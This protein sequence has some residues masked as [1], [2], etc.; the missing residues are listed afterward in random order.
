MKSARWNYVPREKLCMK[1]M[2]LKSAPAIYPA[3]CALVLCCV[4]AGCVPGPKYHKPS[5]PVAT[6]PSYKESTTNFQDAD[7]WKVAQPQDAML[8]GKWWEIFN[9]PELNALEEQLD[10]NNENIK[11]SF[12]NFMAARA[13]V[14]EARAQY[15]PTLTAA[16]SVSHSMTSG[17]LGTN[18]GTVNAGRQSTIYTLPVE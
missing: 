2:A 7:G 5:A 9:D 6:A 3:L 17:N 1:R 14:R 12:E 15:F 16:P 18:N 4:L 10:I 13:M 11:V 8:R